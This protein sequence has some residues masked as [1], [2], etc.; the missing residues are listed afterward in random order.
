MGLQRDGRQSLRLAIGQVA[1]KD[2]RHLWDGC[3]GGTGGAQAGAAGGAALWLTLLFESRAYQAHL[4]KHPGEYYKCF[5]RQESPARQPHQ[6]TKEL[7]LPCKEDS[8]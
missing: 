8:V 2:G 1:G 7:K 5:G 6:S 4:S 3:D